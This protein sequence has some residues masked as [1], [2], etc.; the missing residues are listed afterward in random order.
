VERPDG[1]STVSVTSDEPDAP[2]VRFW[3]RAA[4]PAGT[5]HYEQDSV[6]PRPRTAPREAHA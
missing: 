3:I 4:A 5:S 6:H 2:S 1:W